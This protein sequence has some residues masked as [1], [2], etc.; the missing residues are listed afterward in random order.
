M[1]AIVGD[2]D[3]KRLFTGRYRAALLDE[4][5][6]LSA[7]T[8]ILVEVHAKRTAIDRRS[9]FWGMERLEEILAYWPAQQLPVPF[10]IFGWLPQEVYS[11]FDY[12]LLNNVGVK[13]H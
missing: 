3:S 13:Y 12:L 11:P 8:T 6:D 5:I 1:I 4:E 2:G 9:S 10:H 7:A